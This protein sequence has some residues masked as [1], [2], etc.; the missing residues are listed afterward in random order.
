MGEI[1]STFK[2]YCIRDA[3]ATVHIAEPLLDDMDEFN[4]RDMYFN[5]IHPLANII[6]QMN[7]RGVWINLDRRQ[8]A[9][10]DINNVIDKNQLALNEVAGREISVNGD[11]LRDWLYD[12][13]KLGGGRRAGSKPSTNKAMLK[14]LAEKYPDLE[15]VFNL[16]L[17]IRT[18]KKLINTFL[19][20][21][22]EVDANGRLHP[23]FRIGPVTGR[24][25]CKRPNFQNIPPGVCRS[26]FAAPPG[27]VFVG[28]D[29]SQVE[30]R[31]FAILS[32]A[33]GLLRVLAE[34]GDIHDYNT[35]LVFGI[36][37]GTVDAKVW[38]HFRGYAKRFLFGMIY[39]GSESTLIRAVSGAYA[40]AGQK[41]SDVA[42]KNA[43]NRFF[44]AN[45]EAR[46][47]MQICRSTALVKHIMY[48]AFGRPRMFFG[49]REE[50]PG[51]GGNY[52]MQ[53]GA[54]DLIN[55]R[56]LIIDKEVPG[57]LLIQV[58]DF[59][60]IETREENGETVAHQLKEILEAPCK[61]LDGFSFPVEVKI[62]KDW[63]EV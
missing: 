31:I 51:Q 32:G 23:S 22:G 33:R 42:V 43:M 34:G 37:K 54:G 19:E 62:G 25:A 58:H 8:H 46:I 57:D 21:A 6:A 52:P 13:L 16:I 61:Q 7:R 60:M 11:S 56:M 29:Y 53:S 27:Y 14:A 40:D 45:P 44:E 50:I 28:A 55:E 2:E 47:F 12:D 48:N 35:E 10:D 38:K 1:S 59:V 3:V 63:S 5:V 17:G 41:V 20:V 15:P 4:V 30:V 49:T 9:I 26:I 39:G 36:K 18:N 24:L